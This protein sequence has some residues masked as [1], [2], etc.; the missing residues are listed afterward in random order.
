MQNTRILGFVYEDFSSGDLATL[1]QI[2]YG[3]Q[4]LR[5]C[6]IVSV[7]F[8]GGQIEFQVAYRMFGNILVRVTFLKI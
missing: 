3:L 4:L 1:R 7:N 5:V 8:R 2:L 6:K